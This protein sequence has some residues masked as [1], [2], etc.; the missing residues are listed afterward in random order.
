MR[1]NADED[2]CHSAAA[3]GQEQKDD[4]RNDEGA[5]ERQCR[6]RECACDSVDERR[7]CAVKQVPKT[8]R[9]ISGNQERNKA[10]SHNEN[11]EEQNASKERP[12]KRDY[13]D[14]NARERYLCY[15]ENA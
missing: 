7:Y 11:N 4:N 1:E 3:G 12:D 8:R 6:L 2:I 14:K 10:D 15:R 9:V 13:Q 5:F